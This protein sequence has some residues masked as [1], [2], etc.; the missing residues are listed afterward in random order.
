MSAVMEPRL[1]RG[2]QRGA[3]Q[4]Q[5]CGAS[6][7]WFAGVQANPHKRLRSLYGARMMTQYRGIPLGELSPHAYA[8][9]EQVRTCALSCALLCQGPDQESTSCLDKTLLLCQGQSRPCDTERALEGIEIIQGARS[10]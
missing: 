3:A 2:T 9:A 5:S 1:H 6:T 4:W 8:I 7:G 10:L